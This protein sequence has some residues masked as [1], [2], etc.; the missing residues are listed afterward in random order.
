M[1]H[2]L[3]NEL[4]DVWRT[5][6]ATVDI[7]GRINGEQCAA[8][9][10]YY[11]LF[12]LFPLFALLLTTGSAFVSP[13]NV[14]GILQDFL[15][16][17]ATQQKFIWES[18]QHLERA[19]GGVSVL[20]ILILTWCSLRFFHAL[21]HAVNDA[22]HTHSIP[23]W[24]M[25]LKNLLMMTILMSA[26]LMGLIVPALL[27]GVSRWLLAGEALLEARFPAFDMHAIS[28]LLDLSRYALGSI[29]LFYS[30]TL[31]YLLAP[32]IRVRFSQVWMAALLVTFALQACQIAFVNYLPRFVNYGI[33]GAVGGMMLL[34]L[35]VY[36]SGM[37]I[38]L[39]GCF[40]AARAGI[41]GET[42]IPSSS[43][44]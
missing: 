44:N 6:T 38:I 40:C 26:L 31:L 13:D 32:Q 25:P 4:R 8:A 5:I 29:V 15:P 30:F 20:S 14:A 3:R 1:S 12:S 9:F 22:W 35:W 33:Y 19:R 18:V 34:L 2:E 36:T 21:I 42:L 27:Q 24:Q 11:V 23:W 16:F 7:Y 17:D 10:A 37:I 28:A 41:R 43:G 39:G